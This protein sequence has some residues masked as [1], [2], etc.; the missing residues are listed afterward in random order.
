MVE[1]RG[2]EAQI[3][4]ILDSSDAPMTTK[5]IRKQLAANGQHL[6]RQEVNSILYSGIGSGKFS[7][8]IIHDAAPEWSIAGKQVQKKNN[9]SQNSASLQRLP[10]AEM[11]ADETKDQELMSLIKSFGS[12]FGLDLVVG[13]SQM[14]TNDPLLTTEL[15]DEH[16]VVSVNTEHPLSSY[17]L[18]QPGGRDALMA[19][20]ALEGATFRELSYEERDLTVFGKIREK[21][22]R[23]LA[24]VGK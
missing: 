5:Q 1:D 9:N 2:I 23:G 21:L 22:M 14:S 13:G 3:V 24:F 11:K 6:P 7:R 17:L 12:S 20:A 15:L 19:F 18:K 4:N 10:D 8:D 16:V